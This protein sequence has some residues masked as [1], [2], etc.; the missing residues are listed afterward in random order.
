MQLCVK[1][2]VDEERVAERGGKKA[3]TRL[4]TTQQRLGVMQT[5]RTATA[6]FIPAAVPHSSVSRRAVYTQLSD[7]GAARVRNNDPSGPGRF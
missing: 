1:E 5:G 2:K 7:K 3:E 4:L 6:R